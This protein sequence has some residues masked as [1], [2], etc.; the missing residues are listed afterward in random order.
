V[1]KIEH[2]LTCLIEESAEVA[3]AACKTQRFGSNHI[4]P[5]KG[6]MNVRVLERELADLMAVA[7]LLGLKVRDEDKEAKK[8]KLAKY[9]ELSREVGALD[10]STVR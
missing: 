1:N 4:W 7:D 2:L 3:H 6:E 10:Q 5:G 9:M 8:V